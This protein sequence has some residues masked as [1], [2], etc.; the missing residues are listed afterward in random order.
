MLSSGTRSH[1]LGSSGTRSH[2]LGSSV[3]SASNT[4]HSAHSDDWQ[5]QQQQQHHYQQ[6]HHHYQQQQQQ[7]FS[8][9]APGSDVLSALTGSSGEGQEDGRV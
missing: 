8:V 9:L 1:Q 4:Q 7:P 2:Q 6:Q 5:Q 3:P